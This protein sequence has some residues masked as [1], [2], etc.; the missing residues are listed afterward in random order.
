MVKLYKPRIKYYQQAYKGYKVWTL[1]L[2]S[3]FFE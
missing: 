2:W 3:H 1:E